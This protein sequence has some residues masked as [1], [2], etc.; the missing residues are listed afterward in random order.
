MNE[1]RL[2]GGFGGPIDPSGGVVIV[3]IFIV[4]IFNR[5]PGNYRFVKG[6]TSSSQ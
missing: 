1:A 6:K 4:G 5:V 2:T 3:S